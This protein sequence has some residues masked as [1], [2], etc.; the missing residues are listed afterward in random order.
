M[1]A[2]YAV[3]TRSLT[4]GACVSRKLRYPTLATAQR[5]LDMLDGARVVYF[6]ELGCQDWHLTHE[7]A[8]K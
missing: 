4:K 6:C 3:L 8:W 5:A 2:G 1:S 7:R